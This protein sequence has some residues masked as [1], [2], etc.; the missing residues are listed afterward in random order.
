MHKIEEIPT[1]RCPDGSTSRLHAREKRNFAALS[2]LQFV[3]KLLSVPL[4][5]YLLLAQNCEGIVV[6]CALISSIFNLMMFTGAKEKTASAGVACSVPGATKEAV[7]SV[8]PQFSKPP[9]YRSG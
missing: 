8:P 6:N 5:V 7:V 2:R 3:T 9:Q 1:Y 4:F